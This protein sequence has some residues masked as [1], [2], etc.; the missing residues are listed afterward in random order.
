MVSKHF[1][2]SCTKGKLMS[3]QKYKI[4]TPTVFRWPSRKKKPEPFLEIYLDERPHLIIDVR[5]HDDGKSEV[6][7]LPFNQLRKFERKVEECEKR[8]EGYDPSH[9]YDELPAVKVKKAPDMLV[10]TKEGHIVLLTSF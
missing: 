1:L 4:M 7:A 3:Y 9:F 10:K 5:H 6:I 8:G 2:N